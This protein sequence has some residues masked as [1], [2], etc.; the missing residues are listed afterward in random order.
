MSN[1]GNHRGGVRKIMKIIKVEFTERE[2]KKVSEL[3]KNYHNSKSRNISW[4]RFILSLI[5]NY[6]EVKNK[7]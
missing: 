3:K 4:T 5:K 1:D 7:W 6:K 2:F